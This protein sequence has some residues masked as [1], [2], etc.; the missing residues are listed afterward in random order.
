M[1][2][3]SLGAQVSGLSLDPTNSSS[4]YETARVGDGMVHEIRAD[5][6]DYDAVRDPIR[7]LDAEVVIH[8]AAQ[9][10]V[11]RS[12]DQPRQTFDTNVMGTVNVLEAVRG[13]ENVR[14]VVIVTSDK[15]YENRGWEWG[16]REC[17]PLGGHDAYSSS[18][19]AAEI[20]TAA[21]RRAFFSDGAAVAV[22]SVRAGN[23]I[24]GGDWAEER[25]LPDMARA[26]A[27]GSPLRIRNPGAVRPWQHVLNPLSG[28][29]LLAQQL[30]STPELGEAWN[31]GPSDEDSLPVSWIVDQARARWG[32][33][34]RVEVDDGLH[35]HEATY[36]KLDSSKARAR[37]AWLPPV[38][39]SVGIDS[40]IAWYE[41]FSSSADMNS[42][43]ADQIAKLTQLTAPA[44]PSVG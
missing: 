9:S 29:L 5:I 24:G 28:Y 2:L 8:M 41:A 13:S 20:V 36:L 42:V 11:R 26:V 18:K 31:F 4:L 43:T 22:A 32:G 23:V 39:L 7:A 1:W 34:P 30:W 6:R 14:V 10:L 25:L 27:D 3:Q 19:A 35:P 17:D 12:Y 37:L 40:T 44:E 33:R 21:Y 16:Y 15:C 38:A